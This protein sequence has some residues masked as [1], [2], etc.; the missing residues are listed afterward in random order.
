[1]WIHRTSKVAKSCSYN[2]KKEMYQKLT[3]LFIKQCQELKG[4][5][6]L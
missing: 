6:A 2:L 3:H 4:R 1:M 5:N